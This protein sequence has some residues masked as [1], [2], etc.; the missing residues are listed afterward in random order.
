MLLYTFYVVK[1]GGTFIQSLLSKKALF[2]ITLRWVCALEPTC[3]G[4]SLGERDQ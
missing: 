1:I 4:P 3:L 2:K